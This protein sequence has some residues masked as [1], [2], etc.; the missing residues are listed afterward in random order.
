[1]HQ[2]RGG[3]GLL[4]ELVVVKMYADLTVV[5]DAD[6]ND[7]IIGNFMHPKKPLRLVH[8]DWRYRMCTQGVRGHQCMNSRGRRV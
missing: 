6:K 4:D 3:G 8:T 5:L 2:C 1:M 7:R